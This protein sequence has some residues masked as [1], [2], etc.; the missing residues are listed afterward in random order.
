MVISAVE[1]SPELQ[2]VN[3]GPPYPS[4]LEFTE[5]QKLYLG[6]G[7]CGVLAC[8]I[9]NLIQIFKKKFQILK[10]DDITSEVHTKADRFP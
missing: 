1:F 10:K 4:D 9:S 5:E 7:C 3:K 2:H 8:L 6:F